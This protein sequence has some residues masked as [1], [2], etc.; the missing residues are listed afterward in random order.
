MTLKRRCLGCGTLTTDSR[1]PTCR[2]AQRATFRGKYAGNWTKVS[3]DTRDAWVATNGWVC[4]GDE[5]HQPHPTQDLTVDHRDDALF[6]ICR[7]GNT[8]RRN[9]GDG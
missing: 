6:V 2:T 7:A 4:P 3:R 8:A 5:H 9:R 1:C